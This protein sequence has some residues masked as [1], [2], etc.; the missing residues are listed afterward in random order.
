M[1]PLDVKLNTHAQPPNT[2]AF[3]CLCPRVARSGTI[4]AECR[5]PPEAFQLLARMLDYNPSTRLT[6]E[7]ALRH[8]YF[9]QQ[10]P[11]PT[12]NVFVAAVSLSLPSR[13]RASRGAA[14]S[15]RRARNRR[16]VR[17]RGFL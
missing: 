5:P 10:Q 4:P 2:R 12:S 14:S 3:C 15:A 9:T 7:Q 6:A 8:E 13:S 1:P 11:L 17:L 16:C